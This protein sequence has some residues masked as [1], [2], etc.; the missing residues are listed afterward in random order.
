MKVQVSKND[1]NRK[2]WF[3][4]YEDDKE[5]TVWLDMIPY[6]HFDGLAGVKV[7][8][9]MDIEEWTGKKV[10]VLRL[11]EEER[12]AR[13]SEAIRRIKEKQEAANEKGMP[14]VGRLT[15]NKAMKRYEVPRE[16]RVHKLA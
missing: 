14:D 13:R 3:I 10:K 2:K 9:K 11:W 16:K 4:V 15:W 8:L 5:Q 6:R 12:N 1:K 7:A